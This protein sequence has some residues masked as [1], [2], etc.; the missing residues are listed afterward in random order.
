MIRAVYRDG[1]IQPMDEL[2]GDWHEGEPLEIRPLGHPH[3][4]GDATIDT[5]D[6]INER[7][8]FTSYTEEMPPHERQESIAAWPSCTR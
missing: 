2:P 8:A 1:K 3:Q 5:D 7:G 4:T 6:W